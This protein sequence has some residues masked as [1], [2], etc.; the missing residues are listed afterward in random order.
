MDYLF[1]ARMEEVLDAI[2][3]ATSRLQALERFYRG[4][5]GD[6]FEGLRP[7]IDKGAISTPG[8]SAFAIEGPCRGARRKVRS[9]P[10]RARTTG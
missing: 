9:V 2:A 1:T 6:G 7:L 4:D 5:D 3:P 8:R 10:G